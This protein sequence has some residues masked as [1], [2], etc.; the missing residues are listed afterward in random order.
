MSESARPICFVLFCIPQSV[1]V[2]WR[3]PCT[4]IERLFWN[5]AP[6]QY[7]RSQVLCLQIIFHYPVC[8][9]EVPSLHTRTNYPKDAVSERLNKALC[10]SEEHSIPCSTAWLQQGMMSRFWCLGSSYMFPASFNHKT[11][12]LLLLVH[13]SA[14]R[15]LLRCDCCELPCVYVCTVARCC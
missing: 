2:T 12:R 4:G 11:C 7:L 1:T 5:D 14:H 9:T 15:W 3:T 6:A 10:G 8:C 13:L